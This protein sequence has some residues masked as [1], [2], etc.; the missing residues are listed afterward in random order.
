MTIQEMHYNFELLCSGVVQTKSRSFFVEERDEFLN[1]ATRS[2]VRDLCIKSEQEQ[3]IT[4]DLRTLIT[5]ATLP[6][7]T[8]TGNKFEYDLPNDYYRM[9]RA[10]VLAGNCK[11]IGMTYVQ[12]D[13]LSNVLTNYNTKPNLKWGIIPYTHVGNRI[14]AYA[15]GF[16]LGNVEI[17]YIREPVTVTIGGYNDINGSLRNTTNSDMPES[18]HDA[19]VLG[20]VKNALHS[21]GAGQHYQLAQAEYFQNKNN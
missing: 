14:I 9:W 6:V 18:T 19:I 2:L 4:D 13:D 12:H 7:S 16:L 17:S 1:Q 20:A 3:S 15:D 10:S 11:N 8:S 5:V 21:I